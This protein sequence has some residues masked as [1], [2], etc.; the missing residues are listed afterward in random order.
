MVCGSSVHGVSPHPAPL[1]TYSETTTSLPR[2]PAWVEDRCTLHYPAL[3]A[4]PRSR[5]KNTFLRCRAS[6]KPTASKPQPLTAAIIVGRLFPHSLLPPFAPKRR[7]LTLPQCPNGHAS[8]VH[9]T[10]AIPSPGAAVAAELPL[11][12]KPACAQASASFGQ[13]S[14]SFWNP[15]CRSNAHGRKAD[16]LSASWAL[17]PACHCIKEQGCQMPNLG[18]WWRR[19]RVAFGHWVEWAAVRG[20]VPDGSFSCNGYPKRPRSDR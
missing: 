13:A 20:Y 5:A 14:Q 8:Q 12:A 1:S 11:P 15:S 10:A 18:R 4:P 7:R 6:P 3:L 17:F 19:C 9:C 2:L 16:G